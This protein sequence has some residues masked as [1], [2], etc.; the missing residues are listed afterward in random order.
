MA[1]KFKLNEKTL[2]ALFDYNSFSPNKEL[3]R[4][5]QESLSR[6]GAD[7]SALNMNSLEELS[8]AGD[9]SLLN[10]PPNDPTKR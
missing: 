8:A 7:S 2:K 5:A 3:E 1:R 9:P 4:V 6:A 10:P